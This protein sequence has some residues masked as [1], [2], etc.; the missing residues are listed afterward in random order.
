MPWNTY[1]TSKE[2]NPIRCSIPGCNNVAV[3]EYQGF[4]YCDL[5]KPDGEILF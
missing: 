2:W 1:D 5:H 4:Y 3:V